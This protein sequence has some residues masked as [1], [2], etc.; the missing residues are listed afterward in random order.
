[1]RKPLIAGNWKMNKTITESIS[2]VKELVDF[3]KGY[4]ETEIVICTPY[5][6]LWVTKELIQDVNILLG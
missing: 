3:V 2:L 6:S 4:Q 1:M 5:T